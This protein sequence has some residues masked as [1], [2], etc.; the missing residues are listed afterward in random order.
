MWSRTQAAK[1]NCLEHFQGDPKVSCK[2]V[3]KTNN[4]EVLRFDAFKRALTTVMSATNRG[5]RT[6]NGKKISYKTD[7]RGTNYYYDKRTVMSDNVSTHPIMMD[8]KPF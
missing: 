6:V 8:G 5:F 7:K 3:Q 1:S 2:G 4:H